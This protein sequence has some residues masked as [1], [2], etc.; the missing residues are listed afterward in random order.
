MI[1]KAPPSFVNIEYIENA[2]KDK[3]TQWRYLWKWK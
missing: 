3:F 2:L 1:K